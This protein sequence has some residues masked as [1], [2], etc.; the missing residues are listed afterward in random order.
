MNEEY[1]EQRHRALKDLLD[2]FNYLFEP[3][4]FEGAHILIADYNAL[5]HNLDFVEKCIK[6]NAAKGGENHPEAELALLAILRCLPEE[7]RDVYNWRDN[8]HEDSSS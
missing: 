8:F 6:E 7:D 5:D 2:A 1:L 3:S 4:E